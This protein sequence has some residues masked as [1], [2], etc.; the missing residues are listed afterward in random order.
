MNHKELFKKWRDLSGWPR[1]GMRVLL[2]GALVWG[3]GALCVPLGVR[4]LL[5]TQGSQALGRDVQVES[6]SFRPWS[7]A[8]L[9]HGLSVGPAGAG[10]VPGPPPL[11]IEEVR[12]NLAL[13]S[14]WHWA[15][16]M[17]E[18][19]VLHPQWHVTYSG[20]GHFDVDDLLSRVRQPGASQGGMPRFSLFNVQLI[21]G[22]V[23]LRDA[24]KSLTHTL[25]DVTLQIPFLSNI[26]ARR[27]VS[28]HPRLAFT[29][30]GVAFDS[31]AETAPFAADRRTQT[32]LRIKDLDVAAYV[33]Y[34][35]AAW[36]VRWV[37]GRLDLDF[38]VAF[39]QADRPQVLVSGQVS[40]QG[41]NVLE[42]VADKPAGMP[43]FQADS[44]ALKVDE[45]RPLEQV[46]KLSALDVV[47][48]VL[49]LRRDAQGQF[50]TLWPAAS[51]KTPAAAVPE[52]AAPSGHAPVFGL[53]SLHISGGQVHWADASTRLPTQLTLRDVVLK[54]HDLNWPM[55][56]PRALAKLE[57]S[58]S[59]SGGRI[60]WQG[61]TDLNSAQLHMSAKALPLATGAAYGAGYLRP[62]LLDP[63]TGQLSADM[64]LDWKRARANEAGVML[65]KAPSVRL[66]QVS[67]GALAQAELSWASL[68]LAQLE[69]DWLKSQVRVEKALWTRPVAKVMRQANGR[70][71]FEDWRAVPA[72]PLTSST[73]TVSSTEASGKPPW[74]WDVRQVQV[75]GGQVQ[76]DDRAVPGG[77]RLDLQDVDLLTGAWQSTGTAQAPMAVQGR[78]NAVNVR[79]DGGQAG[80]RVGFEGRV[81]W[82]GAAQGSAKAQ[83]FGLAGRLQMDKFPAHKL[84]SY[85]A[86]ALDVKFKRA[87]LSYAGA[88]DVSF[89]E[90][91][92][93]LGLQGDLTLNAL[94]TEEQSTQASLLD[95]KSLNLRGLD[96]IIQAGALHSLKVAE[97]VLN[98]F[99]A[100]V[101]I[102]AAGRLNW[103]G[104]RKTAPTET[105]PH[106]A[107]AGPQ[108]VMDL[109]PMALINGRVAFSDVHVQP[110]VAIDLHGMTGSLSALSNQGASAQAPGLAELSL[111]GQGAGTAS[112]E[113]HGHIN[114]LVR[115]MSLDVQGQLR[116]LELPQLS[117]YSSK[118]AGYG[119]ERGKLSATLNY[120]LDRDGQLQA[121]HQIILNQLRFGDRAEGSSA[122]NLPVKLA[123]ALLADSQGVIDIQLPVSGSINDPDFRVGA[124]VWKLLMNLVGKAITSPLNLITG[125][126]TGHE[127]L[128]QLNFAPG[129]AQLSDEAAQSLQKVA[130][131][132]TDRPQLHLT[133]V[134]HSDMDAEGEAYR[135]AMLQDQL[136]AEKRRSLRRAGQ[137]ASAL[138]RITADEQAVL[139]K[140]VYLRSDVPKPRNLL[141]MPKDLPPADMSALLLAAIDVTPADMQSLAEARSAAVRDALINRQ[142]PAAQIFLGAARTEAAPKP[143]FTPR[144][145][146]TL[147]VH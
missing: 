17:D 117:P 3:L 88:L 128:A 21:G 87:D 42:K 15:P 68:E 97:T 120:H 63:M 34:W 82:P 76:F 115:P 140:S 122:P 14:L 79:R 118:Y 28:T 89:A 73:P 81:R 66:D 25:D 41:V 83:A 147:A 80:G 111:R 50:Q 135:Q 52:V 101:A 54:A 29:L 60:T 57:G 106:A 99:S 56:S 20:G 100:R 64:T 104:L 139:L 27:E 72:A 108:P 26:G 130:Q 71:M 125:L 98:D 38:N 119:I 4:W 92:L 141:G 102:D 133:V 69:L 39:K 134:G 124:I 110:H 62:D 70:W 146:L 78:L 67:L 31:E 40:A 114:P 43:L 59:L 112:V 144:A 24:P 90:A 7:M 46:F 94:R 74:S 12:L 123:A 142:V 132:L 23:V 16:V 65:L 33:P 126:L 11:Q 116:D 61:E 8:L 143:G 36:P 37:Q 30:N 18:V 48:P 145:T 2:A 137:D 138:T 131:A 51:A 84:G 1:W 49:H 10:H 105:P 129:S 32:H 6:V 85:L 55:D 127:D 136:L 103:L 35:P 96:M 86:S 113:I 5:Q 93:G 107:V 58:A 77:V 121:N 53:Q 13:S 47:Q 95:A 75:S 45:W 109:G 22:R 9:V 91:G 19:V 44:L